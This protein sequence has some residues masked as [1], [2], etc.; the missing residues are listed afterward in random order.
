MSEYDRA[1][2]EGVYKG[3]S[4][5][6]SA[7]I[8]AVP[9]E[10]GAPQP[11]VC[12]ILDGLTRRLRLLDVGCGL[13]RNAQAAAARGHDVVAI[14]T[15]ATAIENCRSNDPSAQIA[16]HVA[17]ACDTGLAPGFD[18]IVDSATYHAIPAPKRAAYLSEMR[19]LATSVTVFHIVTFAPS[20]HGMPKPLAIELSEIA[21]FAEQ[22]GWR[23][24]SV[25]RVEYKGNRAAIEDFCKK[26]GLDIHLDDEGRSRLPAWHVTLQTTI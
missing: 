2:F 10:I 14:D 9:W 7:E 18:V 23:V 22:A 25:T 1:D 24:S 17:D 21:S 6:E 15:S 16:F 12:E 11:I 19:R 13:G 8:K 3:R 20:V 4:L 5:I 26:K